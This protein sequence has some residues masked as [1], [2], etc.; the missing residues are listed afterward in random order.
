MSLTGFNLRRRQLENAKKTQKETVVQKSSTVTEKV[1]KPKTDTVP[2]KVVS[3][4]TTKK[5]TTKKTVKK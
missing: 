1:E 5:S 4:N 2:D 3:K